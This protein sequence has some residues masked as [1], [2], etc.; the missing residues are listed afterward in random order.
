MQCPSY[1]SDISYRK[2]LFIKELLGYNADITSS[3]I[4]T[5]NTYISAYKPSLNKKVMKR[6]TR[7]KFDQKNFSAEITHF[8]FIILIF[9]CPWALESNFKLSMIHWIYVDI[10]KEEVTKSQ[11]QKR[12]QIARA[13]QTRQQLIEE[14][15]HFSKT[16]IEINKVL[17]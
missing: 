13:R 16:A 5:Y 9:V 12:F 10:L 15:N 14:K 1:A 7:Q 3:L 4:A 11:H 6:L 17:Q 8:L 2:K